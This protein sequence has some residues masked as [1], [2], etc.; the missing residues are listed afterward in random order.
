[1]KERAKGGSDKCVVEPSAL[2]PGEFSSLFV[3]RKE[4]IFHSPKV[5]ADSFKGSFLQSVTWS[6]CCTPA[7]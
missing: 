6:L 1:M 7:I 4:Q 3:G 2:V 5:P